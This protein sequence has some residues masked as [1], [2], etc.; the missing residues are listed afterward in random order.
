MAYVIGSDCA[1]CG[2]CAV[3]CPMSCISEGEGVYVIDAEQC[4]SCG[5]CAAACPVSAIAAE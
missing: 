1:G 3:E 5:T 2:T 4:I